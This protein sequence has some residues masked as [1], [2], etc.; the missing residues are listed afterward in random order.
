MNYTEK[1]LFETLSQKA[2]PERVNTLV[3]WVKYGFITEEDAISLSEKE[4]N[5]GM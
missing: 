3:E 4:A 1:Q 2:S 5:T